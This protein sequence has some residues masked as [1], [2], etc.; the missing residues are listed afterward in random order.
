MNEEQVYQ[1]KL[2][3]NRRLSLPAPLCRSLGVKPGEYLLLTQREG[4]LTITSL[5]SLARAMRQEV[6]AKL[7][8]DA[9]LTE[10]LK[11]MRRREALREADPR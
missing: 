6:A 5:F 9:P 7:R 10:D 11:Q 2:G 3:E 8:G 1:A 4:E